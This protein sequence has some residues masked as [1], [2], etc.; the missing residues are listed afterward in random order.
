MQS[1]TPELEESMPEPAISEPELLT[2]VPVPEEYTMNDSLEFPSQSEPNS[3]FS[4]VNDFSR[5]ECSTEESSGDPDHGSSENSTNA[6]EDEYGKNFT[7]T[8]NEYM[9]KQLHQIHNMQEYIWTYNFEEEKKQWTN[10]QW[11][12]FM[13]PPEELL[14]LD[15]NPDLHLSIE[16]YLSLSHASEETYA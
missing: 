3:N 16:I 13:N 8:S 11:E 15:S 14:N 1:P 5:Q 10:A 12:Q 2:P 6:E 4:H 9:Q 7:T